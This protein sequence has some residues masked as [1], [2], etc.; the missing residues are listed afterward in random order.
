MVK[1]EVEKSVFLNRSV[2]QTSDKFRALINGF[3][4]AAL[5]SLCSASL[6][7]EAAQPAVLS[8]SS[9]SFRQGDRIPVKYTHDGEDLAPA[10]KWTAPPAGTRSIAVCCF[11]PDAP[12]GTWWHWILVNLPP[13][14]TSLPEGT[15][16]S[17]RL[18]GGAVQGFSDFGRT[19]YGGPNPPGGKLHHYYFRVYALDCQI[20][21]GQHLDKNSF[22][23]KLKG[24]VLAGGETM[25]TYSRP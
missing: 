5:I 11:D 20:D 18:A 19:G 12:G 3:G 2:G 6:L 24:H 9:D 13:N 17:A 16:R 21:A 8:V 7:A 14:T 15:L 10:L 25:G 4:V 22:S 23:E 1:A